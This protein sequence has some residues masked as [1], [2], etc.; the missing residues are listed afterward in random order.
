MN[1]RTL[2]YLLPPKMRLLARKVYYLPEDTYLKVSGKKKRMVPDKGDIYIGSGDFIEQGIHHLDLLR[3]YAG[4]KKDHEILDIGCGI[5]RS[6]VALTNF[7]NN[8]GKYEGFDV[9]EKGIKWCKKNISS[10]FSNFNFH[11]IP[12][13]NDLYTKAGKRPE[14]FIFPYHD[15][16]FDVVFLFSVFTHM[17]ESETDHYLHEIYRVLKQGGTCLA[18]FFIFNEKEEKYI[19]ESN[20]F[21][22]PFK[23]EGYRLM[24][25][26][27]KS[28]NVAFNE[29]HILNIIKDKGFKITNIVNG[30]WK[31]ID[32]K[33]ELTDFQ[34]I[35]I[36]NK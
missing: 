28:A 5:G 4:L 13:K 27:V 33:N 16:R 9:V 2:Y 29:Q 10:I 21:S 14:E 3:K 7:L 36:M 34:D 24:D 19:S 18:T 23:K 12:L 17:Q 20:S 32:N 22:F 31:N 30:Y 1:L 15:N 6:A 11:Y 25:Q 35:I 8:E 26:N